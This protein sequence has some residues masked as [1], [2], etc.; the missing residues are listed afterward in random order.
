[1]NLSEQL[2]YAE[3]RLSEAKQRNDDIER[4]YWLGY[5]D[6]LRAVEKEAEV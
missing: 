2:D 1:M 4:E 6:G 5:I 3:Y